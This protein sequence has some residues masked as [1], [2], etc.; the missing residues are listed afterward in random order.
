M[1]EVLRGSTPGAAIQCYYK[2][3]KTVDIQI[4]KVW[5]LYDLASLT[6]VISTTSLIMQMVNDRKIATQVKV[7]T[8]LPYW[9]HAN[10]V[11]QLLSHSSGLEWWVPLYQEI[12]TEL[13]F[14]DKRLYLRRKIQ[15]LKV[16]A[17]EK[18]VYSDPDF[19][20]LGEIIESMTDTPIDILFH[21]TMDRWGLDG[22][23]YH[24]H[25]QPVSKKSDYAP[26]ENCPWRQKILQGEVH[27]ENAWALGGVAAHSG[28][29][30]SVDSVAAWAL[31]LRKAYQVGTK[32]L[33]TSVVRTFAK[34]ATPV[35]VG[36][37][38]L[39]F[40]LPSQ[41]GSSAGEKMS[42]NS[43]GH[44]GFT[45]TSVWWDPQADLLVVVLSN[46]VHPTRE[47]ALFVKLR[48]VIHDVI[49]SELI[50]GVSCLKN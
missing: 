22:L 13:S 8:L 11:A 14:S 29:F 41:T 12:P 7:S 24:R 16:Y 34:R 50:E 36:D 38:A 20:V 48:S 9:R 10:T 49:Y 37:W 44:T 39:G 26:T 4:G 2:G 43:I 5:K 28:L 45:G 3:K 23:N 15:E 32:N 30:G 33:K 6:K 25:N 31:H 18:S 35:G 19:W 47:N 17:T 27:D 40:M 21:E 1:T 42:K 46:R